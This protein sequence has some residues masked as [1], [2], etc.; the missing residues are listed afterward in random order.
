MKPLFSAEMATAQTLELVSIPANHLPMLLL[1]SEARI[2]LVAG[3]CV[4]V[5]WITVSTRAL[6]FGRSTDIHT[7][8][9]H[10]C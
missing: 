1:A 10:M 2:M 6:L 4:L 9:H 8:A 3:A 7:W 5:C